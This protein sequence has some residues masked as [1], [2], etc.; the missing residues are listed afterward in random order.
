ML[1][2]E[3]IELT[4][5]RLARS[6]MVPLDP[7]LTVLHGQNAGG[8]STV[9]DALAI[10]AGALF[11]RVPEVSGRDILASDLRIEGYAPPPG[12]QRQVTPPEPA[13]RHEV[14][15]PYARIRVRSGNGLEWD[16][17]R[18]RDE[19]APPPPPGVGLRQLHAF[20][21]PVITAIQ[22]GQDAT[23]PLVVHYGTDRA[24]PQNVQRKRNLR[25]RFTRFVGLERA[26]DPNIEWKHVF[27]WFVH[28]EDLERRNREKV[29]DWSYRLPALEAVRQA[30]TRAIPQCSNPR[31][32]VS[33]TRFVVDFQRSPGARTEHL[34][35]QQMSHGFRTHAA[36]VIDLA[37]RMVLANPHLEIR[38]CPALVLIDE[39]DLHLHPS[40]QQT[41]VPAL[42]DAFPAA[43]FVISTHSDQV[44]SSVE[45]ESIRSLSIN[46]DGELAW[47][48]PDFSQGAT[49]EEVQTE[50]MGVPER[51]PSEVTDRLAEYRALVAGGRGETPEAIALRQWL[52]EKLPDRPVL[53]HADLEI[54]R[55]Q[56][57]G[58]RGQ[59][60]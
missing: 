55:Q 27:E 10:A 25:P 24:L 18:R 37:R 13:L 50:I 12:W 46:D 56:V 43:Q 1:P 34:S 59:G 9:L 3:H 26:L 6:F 41:V 16:R 15:A 2:I 32:E 8:K 14:L 23:L 19:A 33:P 28:H 53:R 39:V 60:R 36:M 5:F 22:E 52:D 38:E 31:T 49:A 11:S 7:R 21:D 44:L 54:R 4:S 29:R 47:R 17:T 20:I 40:W 51:A 35:M 48:R 42:L 45:R 58:R 57:L 30:V